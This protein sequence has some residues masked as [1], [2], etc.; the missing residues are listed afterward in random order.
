MWPLA[1][2]SWATPPCGPGFFLHRDI[3]FLSLLY[4]GQP[5]SLPSHSSRSLVHPLPLCRL[6]ALPPAPVPSGFSVPGPVTPQLALTP[7]ARIP[8]LGSPRPISRKPDQPPPLSPAPPV[9]LCPERPGCQTPCLLPQ[10]PWPSLLHS[11]SV[12]CPFS[13]AATTLPPCPFLQ[14]PGLS[15]ALPLPTCT[16]RT[17]LGP[18]TEDGL[19]SQSLWKATVCRT[20]LQG[21]RKGPSAEPRSPGPCR[22][23]PLL[24]SRGGS[25]QLGVVTAAH[26]MVPP[27][28]GPQTGVTASGSF[29]GLFWLG[30]FSPEYNAW[31]SL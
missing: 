3:Q 26:A 31:L 20:E 15:H 23:G 27:T 21:V 25:S 9:C 16:L 4:Q 22:G 19:W 12:G 7:P 24:G 14:V 6:P 11:C 2:P 17:H 8:F 10:R 13:T 5:P 28:P 1:F 30:R 18:G 29:L